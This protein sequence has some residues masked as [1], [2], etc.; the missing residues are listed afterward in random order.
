MTDIVPYLC[1]IWAQVMSPAKFRLLVRKG[2]VYNRS[3]N[4]W[5]KKTLET[6]KNTHIYF[7]QKLMIQFY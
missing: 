2:T 5:L 3:Q 7:W 6:A 1:Y 4:K